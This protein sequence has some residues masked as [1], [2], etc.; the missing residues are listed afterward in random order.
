MP[1]DNN[2]QVALVAGAPHLAASSGLKRDVRV[3]RARL[4]AMPAETPQLKALSDLVASVAARALEYHEGAIANRAPLELDELAQELR[5]R[6]SHAR[7]RVDEL[8]CVVTPEYALSTGS[9]LPSAVPRKL[10]SLAL[11]CVGGR[12]VRTFDDSPLEDAARRQ[13]TALGR[14][15]RRFDAQCNNIC[16]L[17][18]ER[19][20]L[21][22]EKRNLHRLLEQCTSDRAELAQRVAALLAELR[23]VRTL[24]A[25]AKRRHEVE[26]ARLRNEVAALQLA[27]ARKE[28]PRDG[29]LGSAK[30]RLCSAKHEC[31]SNE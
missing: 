2:P 20:G 31:T 1:Q 12:W 11:A 29:D 3:L 4:Q 7:L 18:A 16:A 30:R 27:M 19:N 8:Q 17:E 15:K 24:L 13:T 6:L 25:L 26:T 23:A 5:R 9:C 28:A 14:L 10:P 22:A 21:C